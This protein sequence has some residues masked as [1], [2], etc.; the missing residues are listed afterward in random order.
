M[1]FHIS[2]VGSSQIVSD[3]IIMTC[4]VPLL[5]IMDL[6]CEQI[7]LHLFHPYHDFTMSLMGKL[8]ANF[9][10]DST[11]ESIQIVAPYQSTRDKSYVFTLNIR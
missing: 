11:P 10:I 6:S 9:L 2:E 4:A 8:D 1:C 3:I 7:T 5:M